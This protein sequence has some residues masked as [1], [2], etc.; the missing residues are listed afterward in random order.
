[1]C[2][3]EGVC[4]CEREFVCVCEC[5]HDHPPSPLYLDRCHVSLH[6]GPYLLPDGG[7]PPSLRGSPPSRV[8]AVSMTLISGSA[9]SACSSETLL[10]RASWSATGRRPAR[11]WPSCATPASRPLRRP[12]RA[13]WTARPASATSASR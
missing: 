3:R 10:W 4:V 13:A 1:M 12:P 11:P 7:A 6:Q 9:G 5:A 8:P 2:V